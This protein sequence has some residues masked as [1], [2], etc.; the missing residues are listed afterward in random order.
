MKFLISRSSS[1]TADPTGEKELNTLE[2][3]LTFCNEVGH[4]IIVTGNEYLEIYDDCRE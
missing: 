1:F 4:P 2:E 3:L